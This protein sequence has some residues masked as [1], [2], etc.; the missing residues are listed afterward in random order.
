MLG[1]AFLYALTE[2][3]ASEALGC[4]GD[5]GLCDTMHT[6]GA[7]Y[8][9]CSRMQ[10]PMLVGLNTAE[11]LEHACPSAE[12]PTEFRTREARTAWVEVA[13]LPK[14]TTTSSTSTSTS[15]TTS[16]TTTST[17]PAAAAAATT[18]TPLRLLLQY[19][20]TTATT[21]AT[22]GGGVDTMGWGRVSRATHP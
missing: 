14:S 6:E 16:T 4:Q 10:T 1:Y 19:Y 21:T 3:Q 12:I 20:Y 18:T 15:T 17:P 22:T 9:G 7:G 8:I 2:V 11:V 13:W 5:C